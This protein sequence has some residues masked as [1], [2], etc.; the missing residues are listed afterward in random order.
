MTPLTT[1]FHF[2]GMH[3]QYGDDGWNFS[4]NWGYFCFG[5]GWWKP[6]E[7]GE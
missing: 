2:A 1:L 3:C 7:A 4:V 5:I 6:L